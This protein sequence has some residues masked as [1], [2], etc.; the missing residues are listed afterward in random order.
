ML[1]FWRRNRGFIVFSLILIVLIGSASYIA[2]QRTNP[3][4]LERLLMQAL[5]PVSRASSALVQRINAFMRDLRELLTLRAK[6]YELEARIAAFEMQ[7]NLMV[8]AERENQR[9]RQLL[10]YQDANPTL[11]FQLAKVIGVGQNPWQ[12]DL[13]IDQGS[14]HGVTV[15]TPVVTHQGFVGRVYE[16]SETSSKVVL[17]IDARGPIAAQVQETRTRG[18]LEADPNNPG[19]LRLIRLSRDAAVQPGH[20]IITAGTG[21]LNLPQGIL[22]G[23]VETVEPTED[24]LQLVAAV[25]PAVNFAAL[26]DV[27]LI[28]AGGEH[29]D[30]T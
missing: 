13:I 21:A 22:V 12:Q 8:E 24:G 9:L 1:S 18:T 29:L 30:E 2:S 27:L 17:V 20:A 25:R 5:T 4:R 14:V 7:R 26:E 10:N 3:S 23:Y 28:V 19:M 6:N 15:N 11:A 16:T